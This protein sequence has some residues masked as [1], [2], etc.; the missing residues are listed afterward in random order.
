MQYFEWSEWTPC[1]WFWRLFGYSAYRWRR[2]GSI[3]G[4]FEDV[5]WR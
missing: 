4:I 1:G 2:Y 3:G 5:E